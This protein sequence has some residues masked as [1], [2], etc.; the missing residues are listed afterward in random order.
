MSR[1]GE[2]I[3]CHHVLRDRERA[4]SIAAHAVGLS[5][6]LV[7][8]E[9]GVMVIRYIDGRSLTEAEVRVNS[10]RIVTLL[11]TCHRELARNL[12]GPVNTFWIS[13]QT[14]HAR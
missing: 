12:V 1:C 5:L 4:A 2:D 6:E 10:T 14:T 13:S 7:Y 8:A 11:A 9:P 3:P